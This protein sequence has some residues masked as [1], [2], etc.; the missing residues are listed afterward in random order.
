MKNSTSLSLFKSKRPL[1]RVMTS[2]TYW[3]GDIAITA[4]VSWALG[5]ILIVCRVPQ[6]S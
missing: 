4:T 3:Q 5:P 6:V 1:E 2:H